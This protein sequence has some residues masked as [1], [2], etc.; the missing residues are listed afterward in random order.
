M[1]VPIFNSVRGI[2]LVA[3]IVSIMSLF[4][5]RNNSKE[6]NE[7]LKA[8]GKIE[9][10]DKQF[11]NLPSR[12]EGDFRYLIIDNYPYPFEIYEPNKEPTNKTIDDLKVGDNIEI[13]YYEINNTHNERLNKFTQFI[14][15]NGEPYFIRNSFQQ[16][17]GFGLIGM[18]ILMI[19][20][21]IGLWKFDKLKW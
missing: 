15:K 5:I 4:I 13:Y 20:G 16:N 1:I 6:K 19:L 14:D 2:I 7:Y 11:Q 8:E 9:Y 10:F 21:A 18:C 17:L 3:I 12:H